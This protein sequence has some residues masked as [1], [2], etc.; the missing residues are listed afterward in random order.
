MVDTPADP[1]HP[2]LAGI[3]VAGSPAVVDIHGTAVASIVGGRA[4]GLGMVGMVPGAPVLAVGTSL[5]IADVIRAIAFAAQQNARVINL[6]LGTHVASYAMLVEIA[7]ASSRNVLVVAAAGNEFATPAPNGAT[8]PVTYPA[9]F[10]HVMSVASMGPS[11]A[12]SAFSTANGA[13]DLAAPGEAVL[14][15]VP[16]GLDNDGVPDGYQRLFGTSMSAPIVAGAAAWLM[17]DGRGLSAGQV[18]TLLRGTATDMAP[19]GFDR[20][21]GY[22]LVNV[23]AA[24]AGQAPGIDPGEVNDD[25]EW[26]NGSRFTRPDQLLFRTGQRRVAIAALVDH[27]KDPVDVY[28]VQVRRRARMRVT[29][30]MPRNANPDLV[31]FDERAQT[32]YGRRGVIRRSRR[33]AGR[34]ETVAFRNPTG[35]TRLAYVAV[36][37]PAR[38]RLDAPYALTVARLR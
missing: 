6:S 13:V 14:A 22:G 21:S 8:N 38:G 37:A 35:R 11:G 33:A 27:W 34:T 12:S 10:P 9:A 32:V 15:A 3:A 1:T 19:P 36:A 24:L 16:A 5:V 30:R 17:A 2:D 18:G 20:D 25:I 31:V 23:G 4:N 28:R 26:V 29:V 7:Y